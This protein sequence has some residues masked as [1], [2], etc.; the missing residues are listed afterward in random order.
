MVAA[1]IIHI[2][3]AQ[4]VS[5]LFR[6]YFHRSRRTCFARLWLRESGGAC[7]VK[8]DISLDLLHGLMNV[9][10]KNGHRAKLFQVGESLRAIIGSPA[11]FWI[12]RP[13]RDMRENNDRCTG[14]EILDVFFEP[15][16]LLAPES[17]QSP[18]FQIHYVH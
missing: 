18:G 9:S 1:D 13:Q 8:R 12:N 15:L 10:V 11:P 5:Q 7:G 3:D 6:R 4:K 16:E 17:P 14:L 2:R